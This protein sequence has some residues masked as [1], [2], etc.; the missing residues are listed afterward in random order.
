MIS[1]VLRLNGAKV[2]FF[3]GLPVLVSGVVRLQ[4][5]QAAPLLRDQLKEVEGQQIEEKLA[6]WLWRHREMI[7]RSCLT[8]TKI[9]GQ[10]DGLMPQLNQLQTRVLPLAPVPQFVHE[11]DRP[12]L[13]RT[14]SQELHRVAVTGSAP[15]AT[16]IFNRDRIEGL[17]LRE[18]S[19][20][21]FHEFTHQLG[22]KDESDRLPDQIGSRLATHLMA[23]ILVSAADEFEAPDIQVVQFQNSFKDNY[24]PSDLNPPQ[25]NFA[26]LTDGETLIDADLSAFAA[27]P[28]CNSQGQV[29]YT[30]KS[31]QGRWAFGKSDSG[32]PSLRF[33]A[34][35]KNLCG[36]PG[37]LR[38][39][40]QI[41]D[42]VFALSFR[43]TSG[44]RLNVSTL[45]GYL[46]EPTADE[47][48]DLLRTLKLVSLE[49]SSRAPRPG[50]TLDLKAVVKPLVPIRA[51]QGCDIAFFETHWP[52]QKAEVPALETYAHCQAE[53]G[54]DG[55]VHIKASTLLPAGLMTGVYRPYVIHLKTDADPALYLFSATQTDGVFEIKNPQ[56]VKPVVASVTFPELQPLRRMQG[57]T[58]QDSAV[59]HL[60]Q[61]FQV[62]V[63]V[64]GKAEPVK[65]ALDLGLLVADGVGV[66]VATFSAETSDLGFIVKG[67]EIVPVNGGTRIVYR[68]QVPRQY[69]QLRVIGAWIHRVLVKDSDSNW[70]ETSFD[71]F[72]HLLVWDEAARM[73]P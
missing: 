28:A 6:L 51:I 70:F 34:L 43:L 35:L 21:L 37:A 15:G 17:G 47:F 45:H 55:L 30:Q 53:M 39:S 46:K 36:E 32:E 22:V 27:A 60:D 66:K 58:M 10:N 18:L 16:I 50:E 1:R 67:R 40:L 13:F 5:L 26:Y 29:A 64:R 2:L 57:Q 7:L 9:C 14:S 31:Y 12:D 56:A 72:S 61:E 38:G 33:I 23:Q 20:I 49:I 3:L 8:D 54:S 73:N 4:P 48:F 63:E 65:D 41:A 24:L 44:H 52:L 62:I 69:Q 71:R 42:R 59:F 11:S 19:S 25:A 68:F